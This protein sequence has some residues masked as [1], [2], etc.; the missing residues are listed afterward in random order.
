MDL[1]EFL[2]NLPLQ[3]GRDA[4]AGVDAVDA[5]ATAA[6]PGA[7]Q[8]TAFLC[9]VQSVFDQIADRPLQKRGIG[10]RPKHPR[11]RTKAQGLF[12]GF[13]SIFLASSA[14]SAPRHRRAASRAPPR[15]RRDGKCR[16]DASEQGVQS[17]DRR[18]HRPDDLIEFRV[19]SRLSR[20]EA[21]QQDQRLRRLAQVMACRRE[22][23]GL[24][25]IGLLRF[26]LGGDQRPR[27]SGSCRP[28]MIP[29]DREP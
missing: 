23:F 21:Q 13:R 7:D 20:E 22:E 25:A 29:W 18:L 5:D 24:A 4:N 27:S 8:D 28:P 1:I 3:I 16:E 19:A 9:V 10:A 17:V 26:R 2:E 12:Q 14:R 11:T 15:P 6:T